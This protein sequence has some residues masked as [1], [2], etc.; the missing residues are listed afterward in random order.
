MRTPAL[1]L[2]TLALPAVAV[3]SA[4]SAH[5]RDRRD[6][7]GCTFELAPDDRLRRD[8]DLV[9]RAGEHVAKAIALHGGV[10]LERGAVADEVVALAGEVVLE[11]GAV[12]RGSVVS[13]G[14]GVRLAGRARVGESAVALGGRVEVAP[15]AR[16]GGDVVSLA[17]EANGLGLAAAARA[18]A[19]ALSACRIA[20]EPAAPDD[21]R[22]DL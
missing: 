16:V 8:G 12:V 18:A 10:R 1:L 19:D 11:A 17:L 9:V 15:G 4:A 22:V 5:G 14:H 13:V 2:A 20:Q 6:A 21:D 7:G 3:S